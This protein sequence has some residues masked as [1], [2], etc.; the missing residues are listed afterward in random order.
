MTPLL[1]PPSPL[2]AALADAHLTAC[3]G[4]GL[5]VTGARA[6]AVAGQ[7]VL[8]LLELETGVGQVSEIEAVAVFFGLLFVTGS[9][10]ASGGGGERKE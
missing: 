10:S 2:P 3:L 9:S 1:F 8:A 5:A 7:G 4:A 6:E